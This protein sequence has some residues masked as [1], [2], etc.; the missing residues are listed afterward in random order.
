LFVIGQQSAFAVALAFALASTFAVAYSLLSTLVSVLLSEDVCAFA[1]IAVEGPAVADACSFH[2]ERYSRT[3]PPHEEK[4][5]LA[6][7]NFF[8][9]RRKTLQ[10]SS[11]LSQNAPK[12][13]ESTS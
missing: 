3:S 4:T 8:P 2:S 10:P 5:L 12:I 1:N 7:A 13:R 9:S 6:W 11:E